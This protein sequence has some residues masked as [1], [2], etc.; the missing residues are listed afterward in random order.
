VYK[1]NLKSLVNLLQPCHLSLLLNGCAVAFDGLPGLLCTIIGLPLSIGAVMALAFPA[2][3]GLDQPFEE[4]SFFIQHWI[5]LVVPL[6]LVARNNFA[7]ASIFNFKCLLLANW[8]V[9]MVHWIFFVV[10]FA[11]F[12]EK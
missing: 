12:G 6:Y 2:T 11:W 5:L 8:V 4:L 3:E 1:I 7:V 10:S 9:M